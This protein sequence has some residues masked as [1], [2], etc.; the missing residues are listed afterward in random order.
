MKYFVLKPG[1]KHPND[2]YARASRAALLAY[3]KEIENTDYDLAN[4]LFEWVAKE[5]VFDKNNSEEIVK[6]LKENK[7]VTAIKLYRTKTGATLKQAIKAI[8][9]T[10]H[11]MIEKGILD[12]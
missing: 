11:E 1:S 12:E 6:A 3:S 2:P 5:Q 8:N 7:K 4:A 9:R 10:K